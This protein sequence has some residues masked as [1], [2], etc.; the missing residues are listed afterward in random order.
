MTLSKILIVEDDKIASKLMQKCLES[1][2]L[3]SFVCSNGR[4][5]WETLM[6]N[7]DI[8]L[9][10]TDIAM[11]DMDGRELIQGMK[12]DAKLKNIPII[13]VSGVIGP[14]QISSIIS[15]GADRFLPKPIDISVLKEYVTLL[16]KI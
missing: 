12:E 8:S 13:A 11:P 10:L 2:N 3:V 15:L 4:R 6:D 1:M 7:H 9:V 14:N 16:L 5:A